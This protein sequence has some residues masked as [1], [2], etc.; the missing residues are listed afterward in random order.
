M[1]HDARGCEMQSYEDT[2]YNKEGVA[3]HKGVSHYIT[4]WDEVRF[5]DRWSGIGVKEVSDGAT[6]RPMAYGG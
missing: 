5:D 2:L 6:V 3:A 1:K 4:R